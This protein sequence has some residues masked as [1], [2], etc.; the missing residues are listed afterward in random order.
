MPRSTH[1]GMHR[2]P[3]GRGRGRL[4][5]LV[6]L[7]AAALGAAAFAVPAQAGEVGAG[8]NLEVAHTIEFVL[9]E[10]WTLGDSVR[11]DV[12]RGQTRLATKTGEVVQGAK[13]GDRVFEVNHL[14]GTDCWEGVE[15]GTT[16][17]IQPG[18]KVVATVLDPST[19]ADTADVNYTFVRNIS[20][21]ETPP[22]TLTGRA[23][24]DETSPGTFEFGAPILLGGTAIMEA[25]RVAGTVEDAPFDPSDVAADGSFAKS[26]PGPAGEGE[27]FIDWLNEA[28]GGGTETTTTHATSAAAEGEICGPRQ[29]TALTQNSHPVINSANVGQDMV[30]G[31]PRR[32]TV[33]VTATFNGA[34]LDVVNNDAEGTWSA[35]ILAATLGE[36][37]DGGTFP[38][39]VSFSDSPL[40]QTRS[41]AKDV[42]APVVSANLTGPRSVALSSDGGEVVRYTTDGSAPTATSRVYDGTPIALGVGRNTIRAFSVDDAGN[43]TDRTFEYVIQPS[44]QPAG[45]QQPAG[46]ATA[47]PAAPPSGATGSAAD[48]FTGP[49][50]LDRLT[51]TSRVRRSRA[52]SNGLRLVMRLQ[53]GTEVVQVRIYRR[54]KSGRKLIS[55]G[56]RSTG[57]R[58]GLYRLNQNHRSLRR[59]LKVGRYVVEVTPGATR[60]DLGRTSRYNVRVVR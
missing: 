7:A 4:G 19:G 57:G 11:V 52:R 43:R 23:T 9:L 26:L 40:Q 25:K 50:A 46:P 2:P 51:T 41:I 38:L 58:T 35:T 22:G 56:F 37:A 60:T 28:V 18:D 55:S 32:P 14:G 31:G 17:D 10:G 13:P 33:E 47:T 39:V 21:E 45:G 5:R 1:A 30:I 16:P 15:P 3:Q 49:L 27:V 54:T 36:L 29:T 24:G 8:R 59:S 44:P 20:F 42:T 53:E 12:F 34:D 48:L 6:P